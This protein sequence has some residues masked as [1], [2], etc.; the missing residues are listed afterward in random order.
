MPS[1]KNLFAGVLLSKF[2]FTL[3]T[4]KSYWPIGLLHAYIY[5][6]LFNRKYLANKFSFSEGE[7]NR[8]HKENKLN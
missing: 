5:K 7:N 3:F 1:I 6:L 4:E 8:F 2:D